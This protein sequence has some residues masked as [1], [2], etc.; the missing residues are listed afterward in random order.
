ML[1]MKY[2]QTNGIHA[3]KIEKNCNKIAVFLVNMT[4]DEQNKTFTLRWP[5]V[6]PVH[7]THRNVPA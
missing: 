2:C 1:M 5:L 7:Y 4:G 6:K 3:I